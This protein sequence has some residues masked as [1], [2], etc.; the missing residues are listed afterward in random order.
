M[1]NPIL[2]LPVLIICIV[3]VLAY[4]QISND[5]LLSIPSAGDGFDIYKGALLAPILQPRVPGSTGSTAVQKHF[6]DFFRNK[7]PKWNVEFQNSSQTT[8]TSNGKEL[9]FVNVITSRDPPNT[10][11]GDVGRLTL[12]A[13]YD[14]LSTIEG[15]IGAI[16][17]AA[18]CA[19]LM[20]A[21]R[22]ID[23][24][25]TS[26]WDAMTAEDDLD[27]DITSRGIQILF[28]DGEEAFRKWSDADSVY[29]ARALAEE[30]ENKPHAAMSSHRNPLES[31]ELFVLLDLLGA[32]GSQIPSYFLTTHWAYQS[33][34]HV[35]ARLRG[36]K[37]FK[38]SPNHPSKKPSRQQK[39]TLFLPQADKK[40]S[41][42]YPSGMGDD[43]VPFL[44]RGVEVLHLI[45]GNFPDVWH[46][47][48]DDGEHLDL[49]VVEDWAKLITAFSAEW[50][51]L[52]S[53][54]KLGTRDDQ[55]YV[56]RT[57][58]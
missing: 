4:A 45:P 24:A 29:G 42:F 58:L 46:T 1:H 53:F 17:S 20:H 15:F 19:M 6:V 54:M 55:P 51:E 13:H 32:S 56:D 18:P 14:S 28:L 11:P 2:F 43:H 10:R 27:G 50:M 30:W 23:D 39:E 34:A 36:L 40:A 12:V 8:P 9:P 21:A 26:K 49:D 44:Q 41:Q 48:S 33:L 37:Q 3:K 38:S 7:L 31:I 22:S 57:E 25:L 16:D 47:M 35:E 5:T 52:E